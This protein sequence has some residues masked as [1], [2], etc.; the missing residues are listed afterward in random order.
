[1]EIKEIVHIIDLQ[2]FRNYLTNSKNTDM[3]DLVS[4]YK[5]VKR[6]L[7]I[8]AKDY[9]VY[10]E[11]IRHYSNPPRMSDLSVVSLAI[12]AEA[13]EIGS[14]NLLWSK[15]AKDYSKYFPS[16]G[17]RTTY[18][19]RRKQLREFLLI[20]TELMSSDITNKEEDL[21][22]DSIPIP[23]CKIIRERSSRACRRPQYDE[24]IA[25]KGKSKILGG[26]FIGY[27]LHLITT[28]TGVY[29]DVL[30]T[31]GNEHDNIFLKLLSSQDLHLSNKTMLADRGYIGKQLHL[32]LIQTIG[33]KVDVPYRRNQRDY[34]KYDQVK[35]I[36]R[37]TIEVVFSQY[38]DEF[39]L[40]R[41]YAKRFN[42]FEIR[43]LT[44]VA[45][46][47]FKQYWNKLNGNAI[48]QTK[49]ALAA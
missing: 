10:G 22:I 35:K 44:K 40:R 42:G 31:S 25:K 3:H 6:I 15:M 34:K 43:I 12:T 7:A 1:M 9:L 23:T 11:N 5:K 41:N 45:S 48:N 2:Y 16:P 24:V 8:V 37:R 20:C 39:H 19:R 47:T 21:I 33:L 4:I 30:I 18:N 49:H 13:L 28:C 27:K 36:K 38:C 46:K 14:E 26:W 17:H 29:T 32:D